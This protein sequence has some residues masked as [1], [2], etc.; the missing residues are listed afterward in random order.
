MRI[1]LAQINSTV[2][3]IRGNVNLIVDR[4]R[5]ARDGGADLVVFPELAISGYPPE[6]LLL[7]DNFLDSCREALDEVAASCGRMVVVVGLPL[8][9]G[10]V[11]FNA[12]AVVANG[13]VVGWYRKIW[14]PNYGVFD[15]KRYFVPGDRLSVLEVGS[16]KIAVTI[17][18]DIWIENGP[19][20]VAAREGDASIIVNLSMSPYHR[21]KG[22]ER[23]AILGERAK[24]A[25]AYV[26]YTNGVGGQ[27]ELVFDGQSLVVDASGNVVARAGQFQEELLMVDIDAPSAIIQRAA[28]VVAAE[29]AGKWP[30]D[31][32]AVRATAMEAERMR[33][34]GGATAQ[35]AEVSVGGASGAGCLSFEPR[36]CE[37]LSPEAEVYAAVC[38]GVEDYT[39]KNGFQQVVMGVSG[40]VD[41][42]LTACIAAD[43]L[44]ADRVNA[45]S[46]P[47]RFSSE[48]TRSDAREVVERLAAHYWE[49]PIE[50]VFGAYL[51]IL[52]PYLTQG[53][54]GI[55]EQNIQARIRG[56]L[57]MALSNK[58]GWLVLT[59]GNKSETAVGYAT[60][61]GDMAGG[62]AVLKDVPKTLVYKL[63]EY[64]NSLEPG[65]GPI[66]ESTISRAPSA[67]LAANQTD[68]DS[69][70]PY[71]ILDQIIEAYVVRDDSVDEIAALGMDR[72]LVKRVVGLIDGNEYKRRQG[73]PGVRIT[74]K[75]FGKDRRLPITNRYR[76]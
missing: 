32:I 36:V 62:F 10:E 24:A 39:G 54:P 35:G 23:V 26:C 58:F 16:A 51:D 22:A 21:G 2:G 67:E 70:P 37:P 48:G 13:A 44:G 66:P 46:M 17:C 57:L 6:D 41:S 1:A 30:I 45:V 9:E 72:D 40:G 52:A 34:P 19:G 8:R 60:L 74:P 25:G 53:S 47:S 29:G 33:Q 31:V 50:A 64:R 69:L 28:T 61:Y 20:E 76:G 73:A 18:E 12:A 43:A 59:T 56:N 68:Q 3:G 55:T 49:I 27:D 15:E 4:A 5:Q 14:L 7:K 42:A 71:E 63:A 38:L 11:S 75:A 65:A